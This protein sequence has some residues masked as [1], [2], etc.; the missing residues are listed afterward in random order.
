MFAKF[1]PDGKKIAYVS[2][3]IKPNSFRNS[4]TRSNIYIENLEDQEIK[5][6]LLPMKKENY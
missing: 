1:S 6:L 3:E 5:D 4:S 2:K